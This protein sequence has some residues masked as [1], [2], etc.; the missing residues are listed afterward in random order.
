[1]SAIEFYN[2]TCSLCGR[3]TAN[4]E[5]ASEQVIDGTPYVFDTDSCLVVFKKIQ[6]VYG[7]SFVTELA[8]NS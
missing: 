2:D 7:K 6:D 5:R 4:A 3:S 1:M 8:F